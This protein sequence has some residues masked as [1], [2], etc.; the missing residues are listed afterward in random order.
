MSQ[1]PEMVD[2]FLQYDKYTDYDVVHL[3]VALDLQEITTNIYHSKMTTVICYKIPYTMNNKGPFVLSFA[4]CNDVRLRSVPILLIMYNTNDSVSYLLSCV[5]LSHK[6]YLEIHIPGKYLPDDVS[7][8]HYPPTIPPS[9]S[10]SII[11]NDFMLHYTS[12]E[13]DPRSLCQNTPSDNILVTS[14]FF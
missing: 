2:E 12:A 7:L 10:S 5:E 8:N 4:L 3:L 9:V 11:S 13:G 6:F 1:C 14:Y